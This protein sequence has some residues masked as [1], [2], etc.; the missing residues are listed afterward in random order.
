MHQDI[1]KLKR[2]IGPLLREVGAT[3]SA[4]FGSMARGEATPESDVDLLVELPEHLTLLDIVGLQQ[5]LEDTIRRKVDLVEYDAIKP[6]LKKYILS[7]TIEI[8]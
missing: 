2:Q 6:R 5:K 7:D 1:E 3:R 4:L 8:L